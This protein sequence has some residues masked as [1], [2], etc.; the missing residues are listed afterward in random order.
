MLKLNIPLTTLV[1]VLVLAAFLV[2]AI[3][4]SAL[5]GSVTFVNNTGVHITGV[6]LGKG[7]RWTNNL[8]SIS[9]GSS[10]KVNNL[11]NSTVNL[12]ATFSNGRDI[13][14]NGVDLNFTWKITFVRRGSGFSI[15]GS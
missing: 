2:T 7:G 12:R 10:F 3:Q 8:G 11:P 1:R 14:W 6:Y 4:S 9:S 13:T 15:I 5:A